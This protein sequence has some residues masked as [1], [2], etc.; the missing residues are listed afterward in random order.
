MFRTG[1]RIGEYELIEKIGEGAYGVVFRARN[2]VTEKFFALKVV[3]LAGRAGERELAALK[4]YRE[5]D[6]KNLLK[7]HHAGIS[8]DYLYYTMDLA[9]GKLADAHC[10]AA[11]LREAAEKLADALALL[12]A[13]NLLHRDIKPDNLFRRGGEA[14]LGDVGL[15]TTGS[16]ATFSGTPGFLSPRIWDKGLPPDEKNDLYAFA[17]S[18]YCLLSG[19]SPRAYPKYSGAM[20]QDASILLDAIFSVCDDD[21]TIS[22]AA[23]FRDRLRTAKRPLPRHRFRFFWRDAFS[24]SKIFRTVRTGLLAFAVIVALAVAAFFVRYQFKV[25]A[26]RKLLQEQIEKERRAKRNA[27]LREARFQEATRYADEK[28][29]GRNGAVTLEEAIRRIELI[30]QYE[31]EHPIAEE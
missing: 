18:F 26:A 11:Q 12:H 1:D 6:H 5:F 31:K 3:P 19:N 22:S 16:E 20:T 30:K 17:K 28:I 7:I 2:N 4:R 10:D 15:V 13:N 21:G 9:D 29:P 24:R 8:G 27:A 23:E 25:A 14:L